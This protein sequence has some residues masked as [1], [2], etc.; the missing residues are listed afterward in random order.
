MRA[1]GITVVLPTWNRPLGLRRALE[2]LAGQRD[3]GPEWDV[4]VVA[5]ASDPAAR[6]VVEAVGRRLPVPVTV[7]D[8]PEPGAS[9]ARNRGLA[10]SRQVVAFLDDDCVPE[11]GWLAAVT[12]PV[13]R[14]E[15]AA[16][17]GRVVADPTVARPRWLGDAL[18]AY[19]AEYDRGAEERP[20]APDDFL[21]TA[22]AAFDADLLTAAGG[23]DP[24]LGPT[25]G[26]P[27]VNDDV[28]VCRK[29]RAAGGHILYVPSARVV[30]ELPASRLSPTYLL[31]R[32]H[33][34]GRS[35]WI[36]DRRTNARARDRGLGSAGRQLVKE[37]ASILRQGPWHRPVA[38]HAAG[39]VARAA[40][41]AREALRAR[42][43]QAD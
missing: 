40:G 42:G 3:P 17:A 33:A 5:S 21:L 39:A 43:R 32:M 34:Q 1:P 18:V 6:P 38:L 24:L 12:R 20:L 41:F 9:R 29:V 27:T 8:E 13:L 4:T 2:G 10:T 7:A 26:R 16:A 15:W 23:F 11:A 37:E 30:H 22:N 36:L 28:D 25:A 31:R 35:D 19:L 14:G